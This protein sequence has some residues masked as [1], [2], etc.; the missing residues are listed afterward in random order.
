MKA[1]KIKEMLKV[2]AVS[3]A[4]IGMFGALLLGA[5]NLTLS[6]S[7]RGE[8]IISPATEYV[9]IPDSNLP[10]PG[11]QSPSMTVI[12]TSVFDVSPLALS[13]EEV[14]Q[15]G[16]QYIMDIFGVCIDG[17]YVE[18]EFMERDVFFSRT[19]WRGSV[20]TNNR[21][22]LERVAAQIEYIEAFFRDNPEGSEGWYARKND[23]GFIDLAQNFEHIPADFYFIIDALTGERIDIQ[24][25]T[26]ETRGRSGDEFGA[27]RQ[28]AIEQGLGHSRP[29]VNLS[30]SDEL[31]LTQIAA[32]YGQRHFVSTTV[33]DVELI[34]AFDDFALDD[35]GIAV[36]ITGF[37]HFNVTDD[38]GRVARIAIC[39][40]TMQVT[41]INT[42]N[43]DILPF[44]ERDMDG[45]YHERVLVEG[46][47]GVHMS[48]RARSE[49]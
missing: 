30:E 32:Y 28:A 41:S 24:H 23:R 5:N 16:A 40:K 4:A 1:S 43:N 37:A 14:A 36:T 19:F 44:N 10:A 12:D 21:Y 18:V 35:D 31:S 15:I 39:M 42:M 6:A 33:V 2:A 7:T 26:A 29:D 46:T 48:H 47:E 13:P 9:S 25:H 22:T 34:D 17:M 8:T 20:S 49:S 11:Q 38:T 27:I 45:V 3:L